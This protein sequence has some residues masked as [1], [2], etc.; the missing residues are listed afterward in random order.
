MMIFTVQA[1]G[2]FIGQS[3]ADDVGA[4]SQQDIDCACIPGCRFVR[5]Q[6]VGIAGTGTATGNIEYVLHPQA[7]ARQ[8]TADSAGDVEAALGTKG[9]PGV[10]WIDCVLIVH[11]ILVIDEQD[12]LFS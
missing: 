4:G 3:F 8:R 12:M 7:K 1:V 6:P 10:V 11:G 5:R 9:A 2:Q